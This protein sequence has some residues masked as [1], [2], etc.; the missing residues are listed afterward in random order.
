MKGKAAGKV[1]SHYK[2][3][4]ILQNRVDN[5]I[6]APLVE[7]EERVFATEVDRVRPQKKKI[8]I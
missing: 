2:A 5:R 4:E 1:A 8:F 6:R 7:E 3:R